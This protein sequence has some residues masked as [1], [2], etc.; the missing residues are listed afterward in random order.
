[1]K[2]FVYKRP[3]TERKAMITVARSVVMSFHAMDS[4]L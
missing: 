3:M 4:L 1:M 2:H